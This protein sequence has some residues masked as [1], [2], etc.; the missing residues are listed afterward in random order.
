[1][2]FNLPKA[3]GK[4]ELN[5]VLIPLKRYSSRAVF[6]RIYRDPPKYQRELKVR[7]AKKMEEANTVRVD[8]GAKALGSSRH[9]T[10]LG[11]LCMA[12]AALVPRINQSFCMRNLCLLD[13]PARTNGSPRGNCPC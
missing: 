6:L 4:E 2:R 13:E 8:P 10:L 3:K 11:M 1:M 7:K 12:G 9:V 5:H